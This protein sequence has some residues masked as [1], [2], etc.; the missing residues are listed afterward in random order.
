MNITNSYFLCNNTDGTT[1][2]LLMA[3]VAV[4]A[5]ILWIQKS[6]MVSASVAAFNRSPTVN[7]QGQE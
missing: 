6:S 4:T 2:L 1:W 3:A 7:R 5:S